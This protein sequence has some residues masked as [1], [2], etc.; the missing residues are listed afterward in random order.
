MYNLD[1][2]TR[3]I[4][5][6]VVNELHDLRITCK[7]K[8]L[9]ANNSF[10]PHH[11][12]ASYWHSRKYH[13]TSSQIQPPNGQTCSQ[14]LSPFV[15]NAGGYLDNPN[16]TS[17]CDYCQYKV[18][19]ECKWELFVQNLKEETKSS[20]GGLRTYTSTVFLPLNYSWSNR[21]RDLGII[22]SYCAFNF[23]VTVAA[24]KYLTL[25]YAKR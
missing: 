12:L 7:P 18:G 17:D 25:R 24:A 14:W 19:D 5:G 10:G 16:A 15:T 22:I 1:P 11:R 4:A 21:W 13:W 2:Y 3:M 6:L 23:F 20:L 9:W 8:E